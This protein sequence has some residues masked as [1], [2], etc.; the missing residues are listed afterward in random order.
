[1]GRP[2]ASNV[3]TSPPTLPETPAIAARADGP[4]QSTPPEPP[5]RSGTDKVPDVS[6][7]PASPK[8][9]TANLE[10]PKDNSLVVG[11]V[12][13]VVGAALVIGAAWFI[14]F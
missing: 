1:M 7:R 2:V 9:S 12:L 8:V 10:A 4:A 5:V 3:L 13:G 14:F 6:K 11:V